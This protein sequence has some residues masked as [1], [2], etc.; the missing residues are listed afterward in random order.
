MQALCPDASCP[1]NGFLNGSLNSP[2][3]ALCGDFDPLAAAAGLWAQRA[4]LVKHAT[5]ELSTQ[6]GAATASVS[7]SVS[8]W[9]RRNEG[10][11]YCAAAVGGECKVFVLGRAGSLQAARLVPSLKAILAPEGFGW[12]ADEEIDFPA[13]AR[14]A[15][16]GGGVG[17]G[18]GGGGDSFS[19][20]SG[21]ALVQVVQAV[22]RAPAADA[23][24]AAPAKGSS[25]A[26]PTAA[27]VAVALT[28]HGPRHV[29]GPSR[30]CYPAGQTLQP[31]PNPLPP[32]SPA[33][34]ALE[35]AIAEAPPLPVLYYSATSQ[36]G[37]DAER[38][39]VLRE[40]RVLR[41]FDGDLYVEL[42]PMARAEC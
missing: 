30:S 3:Q 23:S 24:A 31:L 4:A 21:G 17:G 10:G 9:G 33:A 40:H 12:A 37:E 36:G 35:P 28:R 15:R 5:R 11:G 29:L 22:V 25:R 41:L 26:H 13:E 39:P 27:A 34:A 32:V 19:T 7:P 18:G 8:P 20:G 38:A 1:L 42:Q 16:G 14:H 2:A 6:V